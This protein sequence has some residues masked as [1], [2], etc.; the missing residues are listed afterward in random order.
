MSSVQTEREKEAHASK[1]LQSPC[2][3]LTRNLAL[4]IEHSHACT[5]L[6]MAHQHAKAQMGHSVAKHLNSTNFPGSNCKIYFSKE[7]QTCIAMK[8]K[9]L[10]IMDA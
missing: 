7:R 2:Q 6:N 4:S 1:T 10:N 3:Q 8:A 5:S 9:I